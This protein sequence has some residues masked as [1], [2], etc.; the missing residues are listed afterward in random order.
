MVPRPFRVPTGEDV[1]RRM[2]TERQWFKNVVLYPS[3][4]PRLP[5]TADENGYFV[6]VCYKDDIYR[7]DRTHMRE[8][9]SA[10]PSPVETVLDARTPIQAVAGFPAISSELAR[11]ATVKVADILSVSVGEL[12]D[13][14]AKGIGVGAL[15]LDSIQSIEII[16]DLSTLRVKVPST[17]AGSFIIDDEFKIFLQ[18]ILL[19]DAA[20]II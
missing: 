19:I 7:D 20:T 18:S 11:E 6:K 3:D 2:R 10:L 17:K 12:I 4:L 5:P 9:N 8:G 16:H 14:C 1:F 13:V 15:G